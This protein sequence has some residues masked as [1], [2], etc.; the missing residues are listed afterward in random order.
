MCED[1]DKDTSGESYLYLTFPKERKF[2]DV[3]VS[4]IADMEHFWVQTIG[5]MALQLDRLSQQMT[6]FYENEGQV[7]L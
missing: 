7:R 4:A 3:Y 2:V 1:W 5:P 6:C